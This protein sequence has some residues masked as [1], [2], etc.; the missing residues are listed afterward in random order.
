MKNWIQSVQII[1]LDR[2]TADIIRIVT[3]FIGSLANNEPGKRVLQD[4]RYI[5]DCFGYQMIVRKSD[6][7]G[8]LKHELNRVPMLAKLECFEYCSFFICLK[9][10]EIYVRESLARK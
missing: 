10:V 2:P 1:P 3:G 5:C 4:I 7:V 6:H 8:E 9:T